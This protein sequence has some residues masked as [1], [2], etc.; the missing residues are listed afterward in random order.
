MISA[1]RMP[2]PAYLNADLYQLLVMASAGLYG[3][4]KAIIFDPA[5][6]AMYCLPSTI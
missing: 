3:N 5:A 6:T 1:K 4:A 2:V